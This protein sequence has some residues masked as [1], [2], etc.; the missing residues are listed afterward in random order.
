MS[1][2]LPVML[3]ISSQRGSHTLP[4]P[5]QDLVYA[6]SKVKFSC[7]PFLV[8]L[9]SYIAFSPVPPLALESSGRAFANTVLHL[10]SH[11]QLSRWMTP[12]SMVMVLTPSGYMVPS[13]RKWELCVLEMV[14]G[15]PMPSF[16]FMM[17][18]LLLQ[19]AMTIIQIWIM[20]SWESLRTCS[21]GTIPDY[22][23]D[24]LARLYTPPS[25][26]SCHR[27]S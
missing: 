19:H 11:L 24:C 10:L 3:S 13:I 27:S 18:R 2:I 6:V 7:P 22:N 17:S 4:I 14:D 26:C 21:A 8:L 20:V 9:S 5:I 16:T 15:L 12:S 23:P 1:D 25:I